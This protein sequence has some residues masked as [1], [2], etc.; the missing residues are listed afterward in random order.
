MLEPQDARI[1]HPGHADWPYDQDEA[2]E[3]WIPYVGGESWLTIL[4]DRKIR[5]RNA[6]RA[7]LIANRVRAINVATKANLT[8][9]QAV[10]LLQSNWSDIERT[11]ES[12]PAFYHLT[13]AGLKEMLSYP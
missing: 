9:D 2:D 12:A 10:D 3:V 4:R 5:F 11:L 8:I 1:V 7:A 6:E 13:M